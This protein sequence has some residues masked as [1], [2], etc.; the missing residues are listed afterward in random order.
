MFVERN[1]IQTNKNIISCIKCRNNWAITPCEIWAINCAINCA[2]K[3]NKR[4]ANTENKKVKILRN[5]MDFG[6][7]K[8][9]PC[10]EREL[11]Y[12][13]LCEIAHEIKRKN[14]L[15]FFSLNRKRFFSEIVRCS[16]KK[17]CSIANQFPIGVVRLCSPI[18]H[19][20]VRTT[21]TRAMNWGYIASMMHER[22]STT[23]MRPQNVRLCAI[24]NGQLMFCRFHW[25]NTVKRMKIY[26]LF[27]SRLVRNLGAAWK[28]KIIFLCRA[29]G[30]NIHFRF[31]AIRSKNHFCSTC[32][33]CDIK[34][35]K[36]IIYIS[37]RYVRHE[38]TKRNIF[39]CA[40]QKKKKEE[41]MI[42]LD[43]FLK[44][45][46]LFVLFF[47]ASPEKQNGSRTTTKMSRVIEINEGIRQLNWIRT[48]DQDGISRQARFDGRIEKAFLKCTLSCHGGRSPWASGFSKWNHRGIR[49]SVQQLK[50]KDGGKNFRNCA[51]G[52]WM[53]ANEIQTD[54]W[55]P[56]RS[57]RQTNNKSKSIEERRCWFAAKIESDNDMQTKRKNCL[58]L[59]CRHSPNA[60]MPWLQV[61]LGA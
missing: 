36:N 56:E 1:I 14:K 11:S 20:V 26:F 12:F 55:L 49:A 16:K 34:R 35:K 60:Q 24:F 53:A 23:K 44:I 27:S 59:L 9:V 42:F 39:N 33:A 43:L 61:T 10:V 18:G 6:R 8:C 15:F 40:M 4:S 57:Q 54:A 38:R 31:R 50:E 3:E 29:I 2:W 17:M 58:Q 52:N 47:R 41:K 5:W 48:S 25:K 30:R 28:R 21:K 32:N 7:R 51:I 45:L 19:N 22:V 13:F 46:F 37:V